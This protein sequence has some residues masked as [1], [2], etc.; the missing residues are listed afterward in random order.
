MRRHRQV[1][2]GVGTRSYGSGSA[3]RKQCPRNEVI[4]E[5]YKKECQEKN[6][7]F[8]SM[9]VDFLS[10]HSAQLPERALLLLEWSSPGGRFCFVSSSETEN[11]LFFLVVPFRCCDGAHRF[12]K[13]Q[14][15]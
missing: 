14:Q 4:A 15:A 13:T 3:T 12:S 7:P 2:S 11:Q 5:S 6:L 10:R 9:P 1:A 8:G